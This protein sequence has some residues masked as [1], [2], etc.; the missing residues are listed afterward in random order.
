MS[1]SN[2]EKLPQFLSFLISKKL[3]WI[4]MYI[5]ESDKGAENM[6]LLFWKFSPAHVEIRSPVYKNKAILGL[7]Q[8]KC[9]RVLLITTLH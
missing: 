3:V 2:V 5:L 1:F 8:V 9:Q 4:N 6:Q 7:G